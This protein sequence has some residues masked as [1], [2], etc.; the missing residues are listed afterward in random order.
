[1]VF[2][3]VPAEPLAAPLDVR[4]VRFGIPKLAWFI[5]LNISPLNITF[6]FSRSLNLFS[7]AISTSANPGP[8]IEFL[9]QVSIRSRLRHRE[10]AW[11]DTNSWRFP[12]VFRLRIPGTLSKTPL[13]ADYR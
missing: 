5:I 1:M 7:S 10:G 11:I 3:I 12:L 4:A 13:R 6:A 2:V 9:P 8:M